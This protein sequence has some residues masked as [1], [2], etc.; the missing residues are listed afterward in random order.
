MIT[1]SE[2][3]NTLFIQHL[4]AHL[5]LSN[6]QK[7]ILKIRILLAFCNSFIYCPQ[8]IA[9]KPFSLALLIAFAQLTWIQAQVETFDQIL[10]RAKISNKPILLKFTGSDWCPPCKKLHKEV[11]AT[12]EFQKFAEKNLIFVVI[13][14]PRNQTLPIEET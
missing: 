12:P 1:I 13:D 9:M 8:I 11:F 4:T 6:L 7:N 10:N 5:Q 3:G 14:F 2:H